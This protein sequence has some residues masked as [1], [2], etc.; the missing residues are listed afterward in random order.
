MTGIIENLSAGVRKPG[1]CTFV[2]AELYPTQAVPTH[3]LSIPYHVRLSLFQ[4]L[5]IIHATYMRCIQCLF[6]YLHVQPYFLIFLVLLVLLED[7][8][9]LTGSELAGLISIEI[10]L[11]SWVK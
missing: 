10:F 8:P 1:V 9:K 6:V 7:C 3:N 2:A 11:G 4:L 5:S